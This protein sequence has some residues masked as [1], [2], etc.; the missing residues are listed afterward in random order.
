[1]VYNN[2]YLAIF[3]YLGVE[4]VGWSKV[5]RL[6]EGVKVIAGKGGGFWGRERGIIGVYG[7]G[8]MLNNILE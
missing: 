8:Y 5:K 4:V 6:D 3:T 2:F 1:M 7:G